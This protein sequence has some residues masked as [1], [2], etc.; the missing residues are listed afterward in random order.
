MSGRSSPEMKTAGSSDEFLQSDR[1]SQVIET[2][3]SR[4]VF[5]EEP[6]SPA[7][8]IENEPI[9]TETCM[10]G[11]L[12][13]GNENRAVSGE[14]CGSDRSR[15]S[16]EINDRKKC[17]RKNPTAREMKMKMM[18][19]TKKMKKM[20]KTRPTGSTSA[21]STRLQAAVWSHA[22]NLDPKQ[23]N[24]PNEFLIGVNPSAAQ[25]AIYTKTGTSSNSRNEQ[26]ARLSFFLL[27]CTMP[28]G[29]TNPGAAK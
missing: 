26:A 11:A 17:F 8:D 7:P 16:L 15:K 14:V 28:T 12:I 24:E 6:N 1:S 10:S 20:K 21:G 19:A 22:R 18:K 3:G 29:R 25:S 5:S 13:P 4:K 2:K 23:L 9:P 27:R